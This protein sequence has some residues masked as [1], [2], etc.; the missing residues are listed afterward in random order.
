MITLHPSTNLPDALPNTRQPWLLDAPVFPRLDA[1]ICTAAAKVLAQGTHGLH[2]NSARWLLKEHAVRA[3][4]ELG[5]HD[6]VG[7]AFTVDGLEFWAELT[8]G[9]ATLT[10]RVR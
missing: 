7:W 10:I 8:E 2:L 9:S 5:G 4:E 1:T 6:L 3:W